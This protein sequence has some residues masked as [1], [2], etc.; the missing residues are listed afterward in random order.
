MS[1]TDHTELETIGFVNGLIAQRV[2]DPD[3]PLTK[4]LVDWANATPDPQATI[5]LLAAVF[6]SKTARLAREAWGDLTYERL[7]EIEAGAAIEAAF[8]EGDDAE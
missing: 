3:A 2:T 5:L 1:D 6:A 4:P 8:V 7:R